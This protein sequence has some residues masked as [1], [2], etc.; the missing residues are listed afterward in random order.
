MTIQ[1][2]HN[3]QPSSRILVEKKGLRLQSDLPV[4]VFAHVGTTAGSRFEI[5]N[6]FFA[7]FIVYFLHE[8][9]FV[10]YTHEGCSADAFLVLPIVHL[11]TQYS[12]VTSEAVYSPNMIAV[13]AYQDHTQVWRNLLEGIFPLQK[14][15]HFAKWFSVK[16][17][18]STFTLPGRFLSKS[19]CFAMKTFLE[20]CCAMKRVVTIV[21]KLL[22]LEMF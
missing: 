13:V 8:K 20:A 19:P 2:Q 1:L 5:Y 16:V 3:I 11:G 14:I 9:Y 12:A 17:F 10:I 4:S 22:K 18:K 21:A 15:H 6:I 7:L